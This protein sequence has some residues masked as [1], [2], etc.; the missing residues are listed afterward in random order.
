LTAFLDRTTSL[1]SA[2]EEPDKQLVSESEI[3]SQ[4]ARSH[5]R[6]NSVINQLI[7]DGYLTLADPMS[8]RLAASLMAFS[9]FFSSLCTSAAHR[10]R[11]RQPRRR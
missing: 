7:R 8:L 5:D 10:D 2:L 11:E 4:I 1:A 3:N 6:F 9:T